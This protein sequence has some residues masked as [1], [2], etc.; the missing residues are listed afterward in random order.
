[1]KRAAALCLL[2]TVSCAAEIVVVNDDGAWNWLQDERAVVVDDLLLVASV[3]LGGRDAARCGAVEVTSVALAT[4]K[5][6]R[7]TLRHDPAPELARRWA[8]DHSC[9]ALWV[10][11]DGRIVAMYS[12]HAQEPLLYTRVGERRGGALAWGAEQRLAT[13]AGSR[14]TF[15]HL[16]PLAAENSGRGRVFAFFRGLENRLMPSWA[17]SDDAGETWRVAG[18]LVQWP[19]KVTPYV[20]Y[21]GDGRSTVHFA[22]S[23]GHRVDFNNAI[24]H[25]VYRD[26]QLWRSKGDRVAPAEQGVRSAADV[27]E[28][29]RANPDSVAMISDL[30]LDAAGRPCI[31]YSVQLDTRPQRPRAIGADHRY[32]YAR[33][34]GGRWEDAEI[35][36][37]G[38]ETHAAPDD[39]CT[40]LIAIDPQD[41]GTVYISTNAHPVTGVPLVSRTDQKRHWEIFR[42]RAPQG[43]RANWSWEAITQDS[44][45]DNL[46]PIVPRGVKGRSPVLWLRGTMRLPKESALEVVA[47][48]PDLTRS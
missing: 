18:T 34:N 29:F 5:S 20:K 13:A 36:H 22:F 25:G 26:G 4:G 37:A 43:E 44:T 17:V 32:R 7:S 21:A 39:D 35:A 2:L 14:L 28:V 46:R 1:M 24:F 11:P 23:D 15:P 47:L 42:G 30:E 33:W 40:G 16:E 6:A 19:K 38:T 9:P 12:L 31:A 48:L 10:R 41:V 45:A 3:A 8:D 27:T